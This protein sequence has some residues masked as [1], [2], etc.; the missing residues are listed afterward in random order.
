M[1][2]TQTRVSQ[3][4][5][6]HVYVGALLLLL[7]HPRLAAQDYNPEFIV[8]DLG[9][10]SHPDINDIGEVVWDNNGDIYSSVRGLLSLP[11]VN[12]IYP[13]INNHGTVA[14]AAG[15]TTNYGY[16]ARSL[17]NEI[18]TSDGRLFLPSPPGDFV[19]YPLITDTGE[20]LWH[21]RDWLESSRVYSSKRGVIF[22]AYS[23]YNG[24]Y[25]MNEQTEQVACALRNLD[26]YAVYVS[27]Q[28]YHDYGLDPDLA[29]TGELVYL[30]SLD[31]TVVSTT[32]GVF[33]RPWIRLLRDS[34]S[35]LNWDRRVAE[36]P[37]WG[38]RVE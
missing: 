31:E 11:G 28:G 37:S 24:G 1:K 9:V 6:A 2:H 17:R 19:T 22:A 26:P 32:Q 34:E 38:Y 8:L 4:T 20:V 29:K 16:C 27:D 3:V 21:W 36:Q 12:K 30:R 14:Y 5:L 10:G 25:G 23:I 13:S 33:E 35:Q 18:R 7:A 15:P